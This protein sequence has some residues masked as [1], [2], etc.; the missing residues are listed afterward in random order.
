MKKI[1]VVGF[2]LMFVFA[3]SA[4]R[5]GKKDCCF[6]GKDLSKRYEKMKSELNLSEQQ[7][8]SIKSINEEFRADMKKHREDNKEARQQKVEKRKEMNDLRQKQIKAVLT[9]E[10]YAKYQENECNRRKKRGKKRKSCSSK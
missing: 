1:F 6:E 4:Q 2:M 3:M 5:Q 9:E 8:A 10:Q 7:L